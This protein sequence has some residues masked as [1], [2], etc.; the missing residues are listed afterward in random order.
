ML[1]ISIFIGLGVSLFYMLATLCFPKQMNYVGSIGGF[2]VIA[3]FAILLLFYQT[4]GSFQYPVAIIF[5]AIAVILAFTYFKYRKTFEIQGIFLN[6]ASKMLRSKPL[7]FLYIP[8]F[9]IFL[10][11]FFV[12]IVYEFSAIWGGGHLVFMRD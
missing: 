1:F 12:L 11:L 9:M 8:L 10:C 4:H 7:V 3:I 5:L 2:V 6:R